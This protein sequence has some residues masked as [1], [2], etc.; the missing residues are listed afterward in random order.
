MF[1]HVRNNYITACLEMALVLS[2]LCCSRVYENY[3]L[4]TLIREDTSWYTVLLHANNPLHKH[5]ISHTTRPGD[6][7][8]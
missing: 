2:L 3:E 7:R 8:F 1:C 5:E 6:F 4:G